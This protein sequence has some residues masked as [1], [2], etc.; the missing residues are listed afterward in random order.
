MSLCVTTINLAPCLIPLVRPF[1]ISLRIHLMWMWHILSSC[2]RDCLILYAYL[3]GQGARVHT[4]G[5]HMQA[6]LLY[7]ER[8]LRCLPI[9]WIVKVHRRQVAL[10]AP[11]VADVAD[12]G[13][14]TSYEGGKLLLAIQWAVVG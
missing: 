11:P 4:T 14:T 3:L 12:L 2:A 1:S 10:L 6:V 5:D 9:N 8:V 13:T 7:L